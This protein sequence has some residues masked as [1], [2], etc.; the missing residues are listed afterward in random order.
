MV[1]LAVME[2][3]VRRYIRPHARSRDQNPVRAR[4]NYIVPFNLFPV[5]GNPSLHPQFY[6][7]SFTGEENHCD[8]FRLYN[9]ALLD[10]GNSTDLGNYILLKVSNKIGTS[11][12]KKR[13]HSKTFACRPSSGVRGKAEALTKTRCSES[14]NH[15]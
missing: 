7:V 3:E 12:I 1:S 9:M 14:F 5:V 2:I 8:Y 6:E 11:G 13:I 15:V 10:T 4:V